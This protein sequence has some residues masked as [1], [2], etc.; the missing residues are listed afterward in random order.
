MGWNLVKRA[1]GGVRPGGGGLLFFGVLVACAGCFPPVP[2][3]LPD[4]NVDLDPKEF[5]NLRIEGEPNDSF[6]S[7]LDVI[8]DGSDVGRLEGAV[9]SVDDVDVYSLGRLLPG[10]RIIVDVG[11]ATGDLDAAV[12][13]FDSGG[14]IV[15]E[16]DDRNY[17][18]VQYD[19]FL[20]HVVRH[21]SLV[22]YLAL[23]SAPANPT[24]G[25]YDVVVTLTRGG[26][27]PAV[28]GQVLVLDFDGGSIDVGGRV[29]A[30]DPF[31]A[32]DI[33]L[34]Y[35]GRTTEVRQQ[36]RDTVLENYDGLNLD[37][38][39]I[40]DEASPT[41]IPF[42][43]VLFGGRNSAAFGIA[44]AIDPY[45]TDDDDDA[46]V[47]TDLFTPSRFGRVLTV[48]ELGTAIG[49]VASHEVG[50]LL[51]LNHTAD[52]YDIMDTTGS[53]STFLFD[54]DF[55]N[56]ALDESIFPIGT[57]DSLLLLLETLGSTP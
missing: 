24:S 39:L 7:A 23:S 48:A 57:Q 44:Q 28:S 1:F 37:V 17:E 8:F 52:V 13:V 31:D 46:I 25:A 41:G 38:R 27:V 5:P 56:A 45:N 19:P 49:N 12:A 3:P 21:E 53:A 2:T 18:L 47:F 42:S 36:I 26:E 35:D 15:A 34:A 40:P 43:T 51:G 32:A 11:T 20:N 55:T 10:D 50:H 16:N 22:Y 54:Q 14:R 4:G 9:A 33:S 6:E 29:Y 30:V